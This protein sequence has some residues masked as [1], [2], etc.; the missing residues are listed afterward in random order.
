MYP[1]IHV[2]IRPSIHP[3]IHPWVSGWVGEWVDGCSV[4]GEIGEQV[5]GGGWVDDVML[6]DGGRVDGWVSRGLDG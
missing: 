3:L 5:D 4:N 6:V 1:S 2:S